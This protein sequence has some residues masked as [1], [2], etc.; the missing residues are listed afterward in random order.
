MGSTELRAG[1]WSMCFYYLKCTLGLPDALGSLNTARAAEKN[2]IMPASEDSPV[3]EI[4]CGL[5]ID[6]R[7]YKT[8]LTASFWLMTWTPLLSVHWTSN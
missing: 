3:L 7:I 4:G 1:A 2:V 5:V 6:L 8:A